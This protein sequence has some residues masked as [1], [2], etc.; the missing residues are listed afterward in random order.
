MVR[1]KPEYAGKLNFYLTALDRE[2]KTNKQDRSIGLI[3]MSR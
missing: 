3:L 2:V 1:F